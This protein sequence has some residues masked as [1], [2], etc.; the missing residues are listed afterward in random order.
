MVKSMREPQCIRVERLVS[1]PS[2]LGPEP[3]PAAY[4]VILGQ[5]LIS[6]TGFPLVSLSEQNE[7]ISINGVARSKRK[8]WL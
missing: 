3:K 2:Y 5:L 7:F 1:D 8:Q 6:V 4:Y